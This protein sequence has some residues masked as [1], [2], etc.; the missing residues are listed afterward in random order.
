[1][2]NDQVSSA[3]DFG[4]DN[5]DDMQAAEDQQ[6]QQQMSKPG[7][8]SAQSWV[9]ANQGANTARGGSP[10]VL[11]AKKMQGAMQNIMQQVQSTAPPNEDPLDYQLRLSKAMMSGMSDVNPQVA[12]KATENAVRLQQAKAQQ[13]TL[14]AKGE[15]E[16]QKSKLSALTGKSLN[17]AGVNKDGELQSF[18]TVDLNDPE[19]A[20][21]ISQM[22]QQA[23]AAGVTAG[24]MSD[25][26]LTQGKLAVALQKNQASMEAAQ[27]RAN[28][29]LQAAAIRSAQQ[30][31]QMDSRQ[32]VMTQRILSSAELA[33]QGL[34]NITEL[35]MGATSGVLG[36]GIGASPGASLMNASAGILKNKLAPQEVQSYTVMMT[37]IGRN[38]GMLEMQGGLQGG[39]HFADQIANTLTIREGD[40]PATVMQKLAEARQIVVTATR[41][42]MSNPKIPQEVK[43]NV[44]ESLDGLAKAIP[45]TVHDVTAFIKAQQKNPGLTMGEYAQK[46]GFGQETPATVPTSVS[47]KADYDKLKPGEKFTWNGRTGTKK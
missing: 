30:G 17:V 3:F 18:G 10:E 20:V 2:A 13:A 22:K 16:Q 23:Q 15:E 39:Q 37:G 14:A 8:G 26:A 32:A 43:D 36:T 44:Q 46:A 5:P 40:T 9:I 6:Y 19:A 45:F 28:A 41:T 25:D 11:Q 4:V 7:L 31:K 12:M 42:Y 24:V 21:K 1:M 47:S 29:M 33:S 27:T 34:Q 38:L 35:P